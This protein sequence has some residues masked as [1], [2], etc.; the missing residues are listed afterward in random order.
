MSPTYE[1]MHWAG[2]SIVSIAA[3]RVPFSGYRK[4]NNF[5]VWIALYETYTKFISYIVFRSFDCAFGSGYQSS[6]GRLV[7]QRQ[8]ISRHLIH[9]RD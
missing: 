3:I 5:R 1:T 7:G 8:R 4:V 9:L 2:D 6:G